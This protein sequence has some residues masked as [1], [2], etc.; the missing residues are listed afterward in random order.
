MKITSKNVQRNDS[1]VFGVVLLNSAFLHS[2]DV[3]D[4]IEVKVFAELLANTFLHK[5][6]PIQRREGPEDINITHFETAPL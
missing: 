5:F 1:L 3:A 6:V 2:E 4:G